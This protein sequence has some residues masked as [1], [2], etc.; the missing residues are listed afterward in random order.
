MKELGRRVNQSIRAN[1]SFWFMTRIFGVY[2]TFIL[3]AVAITSIFVGIVTINKDNQ[4]EYAVVVVFFLSMVE[5]GQWTARQL[6]NT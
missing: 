4:G 1:F 2:S 6:I 3:V 5:F